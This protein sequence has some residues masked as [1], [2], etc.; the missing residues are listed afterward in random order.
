LVSGEYD[1][2]FLFSSSVLCG[3]LCHVVES[4]GMINPLAMAVVSEKETIR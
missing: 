2:G 1:G 3:L 4:T